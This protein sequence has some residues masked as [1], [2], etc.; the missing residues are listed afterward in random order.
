MMLKEFVKRYLFII[1]LGLS[2]YILDFFIRL[3]NLNVNFGSILALTANFYTLAWVTFFVTIMFLLGPKSRKVFYIILITFF[4]IMFLTN[5]V[6]YSIFNG[7][8][9][10]STL[11]LAN[12]GAGYFSVIFV[13]MKWPIII[14][15]LLCVTLAFLTCR[16]MPKNSVKKD[17]L[18]AIIFLIISIISYGGARYFL[19]DGVDKLRWDSWN[20]KR[21]VYDSFTDTKKSFQVSGLYEYITRDIYLTY[22][23]RKVQ[24]K[25]ADIKYLDDYF[26]SYKGITVNNNDDEFKGIF[27]DKNVVFVLMESIDSWL[28]TEDGMPTLYNLMHSGINF[29]NH[30]SVMYGSGA[31][32][33]S[34]F[35]INTGYTTPFN[36]GL[37]AYTYGD[38][39]YPYS[40]ANLFKDKGYVVNQ[41]HYNHGN[42]YNRRQMAKSFGYSNY[43][44]G[45]EL[46]FM[47]SIKDSNFIVEEELRNLLIP[48]EQFMTFFVSYTAHLPYN[49]SSDSCSAVIDNEKDR[50]STQGDEE[51]ICI[52]AQ[53]KDT[54]KFFELLVDTLKEKE[55]LNDTII[56][57]VTDHYTYGYNNKDKLYELKGTADQNMLDKVPFF[58]WGNNIPNTVITT[59][60]SNFDIVPTLA[61]LFGL[62]Y[63]PKYYLGKNIFDPNYKGFVFFGD[64]SWYDGGVYYKNGSNV[65]GENISKEYIKRKNEEINE[66]LDI[67]KKV[68][69][70]NYFQTLKP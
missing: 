3:L 26:S 9:S 43:Y 64:Y 51:N 27:E 42:F 35:M 32:F 11:A 18:I 6:Y 10:F 57:G 63:D 44:S 16:L 39:V 37:A 41:L 56:V 21:N 65:M 25:K 4:L 58:I 68:L 7:F 8:F 55:I 54:D 19:G 47:N 69:E 22:F 15:I 46:G 45:R 60:N 61:Y 23:K 1:P 12:E 59:V 38:N 13:Y 40:I 17:K 34:E 67:N 52:Y 20:H 33:N 14:T 49:L 30:F 53:A 2:F 24:N 31:T 66:M 29:T 50:K 28:V 48:D 70:T 5:Y 36:G 62:D